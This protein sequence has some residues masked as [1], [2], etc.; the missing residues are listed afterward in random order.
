MR[1]LWK[2]D[3][4]META[5]SPREPREHPPGGRGRGG[6]RASWRASSRPLSRFSWGGALGGT[7]GLLDASRLWGEFGESWR[8]G[9]RGR[10]VGREEW[11]SYMGWLR[12][13]SG[14]WNSHT[15][16]TLYY[17]LNNQR[18]PTFCY[19]LKYSRLN[20]HFHP[21]LTP[22]YNLLPSLNQQRSCWDN[23]CVCI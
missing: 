7:W 2:L 9:E 14:K 18:R 11:N 19:F 10:R 6:S 17:M 23:L 12:S 20:K 16:K 1:S 15:P 4:S 5:W 21:L 13:L 3:A 22:T 8:E